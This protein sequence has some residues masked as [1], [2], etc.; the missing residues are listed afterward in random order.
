MNAD[1]KASDYQREELR[2]DTSA[3]FEVH[4]GGD[5][6]PEDRG[7]IASGIRPHERPPAQSGCGAF[8]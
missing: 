3:P 2:I 6:T 8:F 5:S 1:R 7:R 4:P